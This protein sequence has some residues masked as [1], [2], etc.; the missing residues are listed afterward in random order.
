MPAELDDNALRLFA[1]DNGEDIFK[2]ERLEIKPIG[3]VVVRRNG[4]GVAIHHD[5]FET[6]FAERVGRVAAAI[7]ELD[8]LP[9]AVR[10]AA[11]NHDFRA[12]LDVGF[13]LVLV[14]GIEIRRVRFEFGGASIHALEDGGDTVPCALETNGRGRAFP[15]L[16]KLLVAG[17]VTLHFA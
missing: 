11:E 6:I 16:R 7:V 8:S 10:A 12:K 13:I 2:S 1:L 17:T 14:R 3:R 4:F 15:D 9:D 5:G